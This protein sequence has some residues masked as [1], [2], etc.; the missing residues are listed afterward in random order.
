MNK[1]YLA[2]VIDFLKKVSNDPVENIAIIN[3]TKKQAEE[4]A[5][6]LGEKLLL[7]Q[8]GEQRIGDYL[9][10]VIGKAKINC[11]PI[12]PAFYALSDD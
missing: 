3:V 1:K 10:R 4:I 7:N 2:D 9:I 8:E 6:S 5:I 12:I 11:S